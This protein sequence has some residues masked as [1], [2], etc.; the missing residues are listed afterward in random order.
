[1]GSQTDDP[2]QHDLPVPSERVGTRDFDYIESRL[3]DPCAGAIEAIHRM[4]Q[5]G[6]SATITDPLMESIKD[7]TDICRQT[8]HS[9]RSS[10]H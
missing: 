5:A 9:I 3:L 8:R 6:V 4:R 1:M 10:R 7:F 2:T